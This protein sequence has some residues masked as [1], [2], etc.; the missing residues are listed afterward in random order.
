MTKQ[1]AIQE[2]IDEIMDTFDF[3]RVHEV[4]KAVNWK[5]HTDSECEVPDQYKLRQEARR[6]LKVLFKN[7]MAATGGFCAIKQESENEDEPWV[8]LSLHFGV[9]SNNE[10]QTYSKEEKC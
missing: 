2:Q 1:Q 4:M 9:D 8:F 5:W 6:L 7:R 10:A 3:D